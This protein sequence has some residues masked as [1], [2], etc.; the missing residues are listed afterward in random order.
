MS[1]NIKG[2]D[3]KVVCPCSE[4][5][6]TKAFMIERITDT[7]KKQYFCIQDRDDGKV[8]DAI[9]IVCEQ[10]SLKWVCYLQL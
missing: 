7:N 4:R 5:S 6:H 9:G 1:M 3:M 2:K 10:R 8:C